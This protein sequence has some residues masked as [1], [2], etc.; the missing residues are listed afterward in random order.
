MSAATRWILSFVA[1]LTPGLLLSANETAETETPALDAMS[2]IVIFMANA[3]CF[4]FSFY[5]IRGLRNLQQ[6]YIKILVTIL[7]NIYKNFS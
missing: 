3:S 6:K 4:Y 2:L 1:W 5:L 7:L